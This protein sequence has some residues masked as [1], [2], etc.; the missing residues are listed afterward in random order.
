MVCRGGVAAVGGVG[1]GRRTRDLLGSG[2][3]RY[4]RRVR[5]HPASPG[6]FGGGGGGRGATREGKS[7][8][9]ETGRRAADR[10]GAAPR[11]HREEGAAALGRRA[12]RKAGGPGA[13]GAGCPTARG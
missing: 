1:G 5:G 2:S 10:A 12:P 8:H 9:A 13:Q 3:E 6:A 4:P 7:R 11:R